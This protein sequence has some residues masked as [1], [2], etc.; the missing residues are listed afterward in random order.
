MHLRNFL[1]LCCALGLPTCAYPMRKSTSFEPITRVC[2]TGPP[3]K[4]LRSA[5]RKFHARQRL[6][7]RQ[8]ASSPIVVDTY[9]HFVTT[10]DQAPY[11]PYKVVSNMIG[12][13]VCPLRV[14]FV[15]HFVFGRLHHLP[16]FSYCSSNTLTET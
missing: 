15:R 2:G 3:S 1:F 9:A 5:H 12:I 14:S 11:Y 13:Q 6:H 8:T 7:P 16:F 4:G 10:D